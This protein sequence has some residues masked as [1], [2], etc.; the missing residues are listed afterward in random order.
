VR[1]QAVTVSGRT[2]VFAAGERIHTEN[3]YKYSVAEFQ[4]LAQDAGFRPQQAWVDSE[5]RFAVHLLT[6]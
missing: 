2:F 6:L 3:S 5:Q 4:R 1:A